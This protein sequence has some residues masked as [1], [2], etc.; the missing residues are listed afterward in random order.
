MELQVIFAA[1]S[2]NGSRDKPN[3]ESDMIKK[4]MLLSSLRQQQQQ[5]ETFPLSHATL[6]SRQ[7]PPQETMNQ[8]NAAISF[9]GT[10]S[11]SLNSQI[12]NKATKVQELQQ[13]LNF[14]TSAAAAAQAQRVKLQEQQQA[15]NHRA[16]DL[17]SSQSSVTPPETNSQV[18]A[19]N[20]GDVSNGDS[21]A[22]ATNRSKKLSIGSSSNLAKSVIDV[23]NQRASNGSNNKNDETSMQV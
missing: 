8:I 18:L 1:A 19:A 4:L 2:A 13:K 7:L 10:T 22:T 5:Q 17:A 15:W 14:A 16:N 20:I 9:S 21:S 23:M 12:H 6:A 11:N 3:E